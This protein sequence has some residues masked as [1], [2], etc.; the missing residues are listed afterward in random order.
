MCDLSQD[1]DDVALEKE[2]EWMMETARAR[3]EGREN[4]N[5]DFLKCK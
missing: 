4:R 3:E 2:G 1:R 5:G